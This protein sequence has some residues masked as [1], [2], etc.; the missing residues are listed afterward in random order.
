EGAYQASREHPW[1]RWVSWQFLDFSVKAGRT[2]GVAA[3]A[4]KQLAD[5]RASMPAGG[6]QLAQSLSNA[7]SILLRVKKWK[8]AESMIRESLTIR[9]NKAPNEWTTFNTKSRLGGALLGQKK[10]TEAEPLL[11]A[12]YEGMKLRADKS[13]AQRT[14]TH[15]AATIDWLIELAEATGKPDDV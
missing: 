11:R 5:D 7:G 14:A 12:G 8:D 4:T 13:P 9:A 10:Y 6:L 1:L 3:L 2:D 15:L